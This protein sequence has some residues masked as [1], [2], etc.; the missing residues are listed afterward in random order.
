MVSAEVWEHLA[1]QGW[2]SGLVEDN[3][4]PSPPGFRLLYWTP[5][6]G[7]A[8]VL[9]EMDGEVELDGAAPVHGGSRGLTLPHLAGR[10]SFMAGGGSSVDGSA[11]GVK[12]GRSAS[13]EGP[14]GAVRNYGPRTR[15]VYLTMFKALF[16]RSDGVCLPLSPVVCLQ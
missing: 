1:D 16:L 7:G 13:I 8:T 15:L 9:S 3:G 14:S 4:K 2:G 6:Q 11:C 5:E 10:S 12:Y